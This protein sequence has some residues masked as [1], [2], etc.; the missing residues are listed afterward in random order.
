[1]ARYEVVCLKIELFADK[2]SV[3]RQKT[4]KNFYKHFIFKA[5][6]KWVQ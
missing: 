6:P 2:Q 5:L 3:C 1:M 4:S